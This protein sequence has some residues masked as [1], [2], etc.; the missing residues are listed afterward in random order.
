M[1]TIWHHLVNSPGTLAP[2][3]PDHLPV[4]AGQHEHGG[5]HGHRRAEDVG[6]LPGIRAPQR[7]EEPAEPVAGHL[8]DLDFPLPA[9]STPPDAVSAPDS[10]DGAKPAGNGTFA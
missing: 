1:H 2:S 6:R 5:R 9:A 7:R 4:A 10:R 3:H 8:P